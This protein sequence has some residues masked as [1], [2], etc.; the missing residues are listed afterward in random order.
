MPSIIS[1]IKK[2]ILYLKDSFIDIIR[3]FIFFILA[4]SGFGC[5][6]VL[7]LLQYNGIIIAIVS[8]TIEGIAMLLNYFI[9]RGYLKQE[10]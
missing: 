3:G 8:C 9:F 2:Q 6:L 7:R 1:W 5:A 4:F 10:E